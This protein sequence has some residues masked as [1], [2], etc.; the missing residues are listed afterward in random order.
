[1]NEEVTKMISLQNQKTANMGP[2]PSKRHAAGRLMAGH[3]MG[4]GQQRPASTKD[5]TASAPGDVRFFSSAVE[6]ALLW[7]QDARAY[8]HVTGAQ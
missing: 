1:M 5:R 8:R 4:Q 7:P 6:H 2:E 3:G